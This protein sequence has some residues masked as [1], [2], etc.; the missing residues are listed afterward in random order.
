MNSFFVQKRALL[1]LATLSIV[2]LVVLIGLILTSIFATPSS[3]SIETTLSPTPTQTI[4][5]SP[6]DIRQDPK[7]RNNPYRVE[8]EPAYIKSLE[9]IDAKNKEQLEKA[10]AVG[11][12]LTKLPYTGNAFSLRYDYGNNIFYLTLV[13]DN[14]TQGNQEFEQFLREND[15]LDRS[16]IKNLTVS[17][18]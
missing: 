12:L 18:Q 5:V 14:R 3:Q 16:W 1:F 15:I 11:R 13:R 8:S 7:Y 6:P 4:Q 2:I 17:Y 9:D 10:G